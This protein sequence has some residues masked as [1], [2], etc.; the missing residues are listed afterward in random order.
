MHQQAESKG[1]Q[2][3]QEQRTML[4]SA[5]IPL[6]GSS[7]LESLVILPFSSGEGKSRDETDK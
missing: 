5:F 4:P 7:K 3:W 6:T 2:S 1:V